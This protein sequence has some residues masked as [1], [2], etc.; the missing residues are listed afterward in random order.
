MK[1]PTKHAEKLS[2]RVALAAS[3]SVAL[4]SLFA[5]T[6]S[7]SA[8]L[9]EPKDHVLF[10]GT[11]L[12]VRQDGKF[13][14]VVGASKN[15][16]K[17]EKD[18]EVQDVQ[19]AQGADIRISKGV[20]LSNLSATIDHMK[21]ESIDRAAARAQ[22]EAFRSSLVM[23]DRALEAEDRM[24][25]ALMFATNIA[26]PSEDAAKTNM[27]AALAREAI[28]AAQS[29]AWDD[30][31]TGVGAFVSVPG[32][33]NT[34]LMQQLAENRS[35]EVELSFDVSSPEPLDHA[36][37]VVVANYGSTDREG[38]A[39]RQ[40]SARQFDHVGSRPLHVTMSH[41]ASLNGLPFTKFDVGLFA[42][43]QEV[44]TNLSEKRMPLTTD[45]A[46]QFFMIDYLTTHKGAT[47]PPAPMLMTPRVN[48]RQQFDQA[49]A[50][51]PIYASVDKSGSLVALSVDQSGAGKVPATV[52][53]ALRNVRFMPALNNGAPV[54]G[55]LKFTLADLA[56]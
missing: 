15:S 30:Y 47:L 45:Q 42:D 26:P 1:T 10:V 29:K 9:A 44:A 49:E 37:I 41:A 16:L 21:T 33:A 50:N 56:N 36:Y 27:G 48:F 54:D 38:K 34:V 13:Y 8:A 20:K 3:L 31:K 51:Q 6:T 5:T 32:A 2:S 55:H 24:H 46:Y 22:Y 19:L 7:V 35:T 53:S 11:D 28:L 17:I 39:A 14:H 18:H 23:E 40:I 4:V 12:D 25:G 43:G 52:A